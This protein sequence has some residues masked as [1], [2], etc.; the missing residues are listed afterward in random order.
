LTFL[1]ILHL[2]AFAG[3]AQDDA[4]GRQRA[5][6]E[7]QKAAMSTQRASVRRQAK[8]SAPVAGA[9]FETF[10]PEP[11]DS[12]ECEPL[13]LLRRRSLIDRSAKREGIRPELIEAVMEQESGF[14]PCSVSSRGAVGLMQLMPATSTK[15]G[16]SDPFDSEQNVAGGAALLKE[17]LDRYSGDLDRVLGAYNA[18]TVRVDEAGG[19]P[20]IPETTRYVEKILGRLLR[21]D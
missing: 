16:V 1:L 2:A 18:G 12:A 17:L 14:R 6:I 15:L 21:K 4:I 13:P 10:D 5:S 11:E 8:M 3:V 7:S 20:A 9:F 19:V